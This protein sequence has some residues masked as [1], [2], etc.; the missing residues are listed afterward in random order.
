MIKI[1]LFGG[2]GGGHWQERRKNHQDRKS[3]GSWSKFVMAVGGWQDIEIR[4]SNKFRTKNFQF[5]AKW[6]S[7]NNCRLQ[8]HVKTLL[9]NL[10][11]PQNP[12]KSS[13]IPKIPIALGYFYSVARKTG[14]FPTKN[15]DSKTN[16]QKI[17]RSS[18]DRALNKAP[19]PKLQSIDW[20]ISS[21]GNIFCVGFYLSFIIISQWQAKFKR[22][23]DIMIV[24]RMKR[25]IQCS[26]F[27]CVLIKNL[28]GKKGCV[29]LLFASN[30]PKNNFR[31][32]TV[33][34]RL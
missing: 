11:A 22:I 28:S 18:I 4:K 5:P 25:Y 2:C 15:I 8:F 32:H 21:S 6:K 7:I 23:I 3:Y 13:S 27:V 14:N 33:I 17:H 19:N 1:L 30:N 24:I 29:S 9:P 12:I 16:K 34:F 31:K 10:T 20:Y 26:C